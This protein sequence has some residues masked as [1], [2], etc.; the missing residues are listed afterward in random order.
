MIINVTLIVRIGIKMIGEIDGPDF[1]R[2]YNTTID[3]DEC[4]YGGGDK[5][6][7]HYISY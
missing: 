5:N 4:L 1:G 7:E 3:C 6:P 2:D